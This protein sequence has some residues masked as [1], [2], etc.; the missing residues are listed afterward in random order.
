MIQEM[1]QSKFTERQDFLASASDLFLS[2]LS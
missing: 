1:Q 2:L